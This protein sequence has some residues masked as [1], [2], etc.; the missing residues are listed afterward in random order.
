MRATR[1]FAV[2]DLRTVDHPDPEPGP[3]E[4]LVKVLAAGICGTD[5]HLYHGG[6]PCRPPVTLG[7]EFCGTVVALGA[8]TAG[9][10]PGTLVTCDPNIA[11]GTCPA[12]RAGRVNLCSSLRAVGIA[13][14]GGFATYAAFPAHRALALP[15]TLDPVAG[16][17]C[18]PLACCL[19]GIDMGVPQPGQRV[20]V[21]GGGV[22]GLLTLQLARLAGAEVL[23]VTRQAAKRDLA[24]DLGAT[25]TAGTVAEALTHWPGGADLVLE[26]AGVPETVEAA[27]RLTRAGGRIVVLGVLP[28]GTRVQIEPFDLLFR[29]IALLFAFINPHTQGRA[30]D[31]IA[32]GRI[33]TAPLVSRRIGLDEAVEAIA[34]PARAGEV[35]VIVLPGG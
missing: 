23:L 6:F 19:H 8:G 16:A 15:L 1:L 7:H 27:P 18:E 13:Q 17:F 30:A 34:H 35:K 11:C 21:L 3:G 5:R 31:L 10:A 33:V 20:I 4:V 14:D 9:P 2:G 22:I 24:T 26:C 28:M 32:S 25:A 12:C 29:E